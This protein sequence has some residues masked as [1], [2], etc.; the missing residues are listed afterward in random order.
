MDVIL[1]AGFWLNGSSWAVQVPALEGA[2]HRVHAPTL[3]G[4]EAGD[5]PDVGLQDQIDAVVSLIDRIGRPVVLAGHSGGGNIAWGA[6][7]ARPDRV[8]HVVFVDSFPPPHGFTI[9]D[10]LPVVDGRIPFPDDRA[11]FFDDAEFADFAEDELE[12]FIAGAIPQPARVASEPI[13]L[14]DERRWGIPITVMATAFPQS[15][16]EQMIAAEH[17]MTAE[18]NAVRELTVL[19]VPTSHWPQ[20]TKPDVTAMILVEA[21]NAAAEDLLD[22]AADEAEGR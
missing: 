21:A 19:G 15:Q 2:G 18:L 1:I 13:E 10:E 6:A 9:N 5:D 16:M 22:A 14:R 8:A 3:P 17:P 20:L 7:D 4:L 11:R 12:A